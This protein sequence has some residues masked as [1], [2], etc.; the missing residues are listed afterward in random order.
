MNTENTIDLR[1]SNPHVWE[2]ICQLQHADAI[3]RPLQ[4]RCSQCRAKLGLAVNTLHGPGF[5]SS[6][7]DWE[8]NFGQVH[9]NGQ[10]LGDREAIRYMLDDAEEV[11]GD[12]G[13]TPHGFFAALRIPLDL[14][15][16][17][18]PLFVRCMTHGD[19]VVDRAEVRDALRKGWPVLP[20]A[21]EGTRFDVIEQQTDGLRTTPRHS[22]LVKRIGAG[23]GL[24]VEEFDAWHSARTGGRAKA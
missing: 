11:S 3:G 4:I 9:I 20:V 12:W 18:V 24:T 19:A 5:A 16:D 8:A 15:Q 21:L 6:W 17:Y 22:R 14:P 2:Y 23:D 1:V 7:S 10:Q 13:R